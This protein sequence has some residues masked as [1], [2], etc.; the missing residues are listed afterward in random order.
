MNLKR[1]AVIQK[2]KCNPVLSPH[3]LP[4]D[5]LVDIVKLIPVLIL[6]ADVPNEGLKLGTPRYCHIKSFGGEECLEIKQVEIIIIH[7]VC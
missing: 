3:W 6:K 4:D 2:W 1:E 5:D 7:K